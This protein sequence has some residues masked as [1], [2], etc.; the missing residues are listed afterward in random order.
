MAANDKKKSVIILKD[1]EINLALRYLYQKATN[2]INQFGRH[3]KAFKNSTVVDGIRY[4]TGRLLPSQ[5]FTNPEL[6]IFPNCMVNN[7]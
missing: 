1:Y 5:K 7:T 6:P 3:T 2:E 4:Y